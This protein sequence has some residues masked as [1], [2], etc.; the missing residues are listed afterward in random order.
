MK[1]ILFPGDSEYLPHLP[2][3]LNSLAMSQTAFVLCF[4]ISA[5]VFQGSIYIFIVSDPKEGNE[6][7]VA[8][9]FPSFTISSYHSSKTLKSSCFLLQDNLHSSQERPFLLFT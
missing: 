3:S 6:W 4:P 2:A 8:F 1:V 5:W 9:I 7:E